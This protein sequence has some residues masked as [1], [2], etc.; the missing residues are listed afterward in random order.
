MKLYTTVSVRTA[1]AP[2]SITSLDCGET[3]LEDLLKLLKQNISQETLV[4]HIDLWNTEK[5]NE[6]QKPS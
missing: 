3:T 1:W 4:V 2:N 5:L 6:T